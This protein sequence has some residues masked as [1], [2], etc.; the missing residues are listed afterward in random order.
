MTRQLA[1]ELKKYQHFHKNKTN[2]WIHK[3]CVPIILLTTL[4]FLQ[5]DL[6]STSIKFSHMVSIVLNAFYL[7]LNLLGGSVFTIVI[8]LFNAILD[9]K[10]LPWGTKTNCLLFM[11]SWGLQFW[12]HS[13]FEKNRPAIMSNLFQSLIL[14]PFFVMFEWLFDLGLYQDLQFD[15]K[16]I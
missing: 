13:A 16:R 3:I 15:L 11:L 6:G 14:A 2:I 12:G 1:R 5:F 10:W 4:S 7:N 9:N 8:L